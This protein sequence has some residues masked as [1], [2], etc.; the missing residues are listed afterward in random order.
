MIVAVRVLEVGQQE[1]AFFQQEVQARVRVWVR[2][3]MIIAEK[4]EVG[5]QVRVWESESTSSSGLGSRKNDSSSSDTSLRLGKRKI[6][7]SSPS[8]GSEAARSGSLPVTS[9]SLGKRKHK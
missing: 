9:S 6:D 4:V 8:A 2:D 3:R 5:Q 1:V 7:S